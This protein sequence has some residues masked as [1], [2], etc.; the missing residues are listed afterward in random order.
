MFFCSVQRYNLYFIPPNNI[1]FIL[2]LFYFP[3][4]GKIIPDNVW[5]SPSQKTVARVFLIMI[6]R[7]KQISPVHSGWR[8]LGIKKPLS[9]FLILL[10]YE[11]IFFVQFVSYTF[12]LQTDNNIIIIPIPHIVLVSVDNFVTIVRRG[13]F[14]EHHRHPNIIL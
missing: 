6:G 14:I 11:L 2:K 7:A 12:E 10:Y 13:N 4:A 5:L 3:R 1:L 9:G 8:F